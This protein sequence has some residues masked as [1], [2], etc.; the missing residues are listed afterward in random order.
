[1]V[2]LV[3]VDNFR[4]VPISSGPGKIWVLGVVFRQEN[5]SF[6]PTLMPQENIVFK[7]NSEI[8]SFEI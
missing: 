1:M 8:F 3:S 5:I 2:Y 7:I 6:N 4:S